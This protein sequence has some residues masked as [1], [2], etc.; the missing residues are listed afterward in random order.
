MRIQKPGILTVGVLA[1]VLTSLGVV[2]GA[3]AQAPQGPRFGENYLLPP[4]TSARARDVPGL[5]VNPENQNHIVEAESDPLNLQCDYNVSFDGGRTWSGG[6]LTL[7]RAG[8]DPPMPAP[9]CNQNFDSGGYHHFNTGIVFGSGQNVYITFSIHRGPFNRPESNL[10]GGAGDDAV[11]ARSTDGGRTFQPAVIAVPGG[12]PVDLKLDEPGLAGRGMRPQIAV[13]R[14]AGTGGQD[15]LYVNS[16]ECV[17]SSGG[18]SGGGGN[19]G[20][21]WPARTMGERTGTPRSSPAGGTSAAARLLSLPAA[22]T[23]KLASPRSRWSART[24]P[25]TLPVATATRMGG[26]RAPPAGQ[27]HCDLQVD[28]RGRK[29]G[30]VRHRV[31]RQ[32]SAAGDRSEHARRRRNPLRRLPAVRDRA[33]P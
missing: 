6:H 33:T 23:S 3:A 21:S 17:R 10:R 4:L 27:L 26:R 18:C 30:A 13:E 5:A 32:P 14:G 15:R 9:A 2:P 19:A 12:G 28:R 11:V 16:W 7:A 25:S 8:E 1:L 24:A 20:S 31:C 29:L 22:L